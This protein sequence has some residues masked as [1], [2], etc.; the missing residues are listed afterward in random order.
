M[1]EDNIEIKNLT[2]FYT[3]V[4][5]KSKENITGYS[6]LKRLEEDLG[7][8]ASPTYIYD[9]LK[10]LK[11]EGYIDDVPSK[12]SKRAKGVRLTEAGE[13]F[14]N[15]IF[16]RFENLIDVAVQSKLKIC[17]SCGAKLYSDFHVETIDGKEMNFCCVHCAHAFRDIDHA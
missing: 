9:F 17:A 11:S 13:K 5:L 7:K 6:I 14:V 15:K 3:L 12:K 16:A 10:D 4:L 2:K 8:T 1:E